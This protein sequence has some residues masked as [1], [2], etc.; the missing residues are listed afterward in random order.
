MKKNNYWKKYKSKYQ[1]HFDSSKKNTRDYFYLGN[2]KYDYKKLIKQIS[3]I[4]KKIKVRTVVNSDIKSKKA[5]LRNR[6][7]SFRDFGYK[8]DQTEFY[9]IF[10]D[11]YPKLFENFIKLSGLG[12]ASSSLIKQYPGN[13]IPWHQDTHITLKNKLSK[14]KELKNKKIIRYMIFLTDWDWGHYFCVGNNV[15]HQWRAGDIIT[16]N[17]I[18]HHCGSNAGMTPKITLNVTGLIEKNSL[19][20][21]KKIKI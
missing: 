16:W 17:P 7:Q 15:V 10:S 5:I 19:H 14:F 11:E 4:E 18:V 6:M 3:K 12:C 8:K 20:V 13:I 21:K 1:W 2:I 9:Q